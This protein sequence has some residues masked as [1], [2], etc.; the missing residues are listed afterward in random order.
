ML[1]KILFNYQHRPAISDS[2]FTG[3][4][5]K[6]KH[7]GYF[8]L[9]VKERSGR[10]IRGNDK[11]N[12]RNLSVFWDE[13][14]RRNTDKRE[15]EAPKK[16][17]KRKTESRLFPGVSDGSLVS[18]LSGRLNPAAS[19]LLLSSPLKLRNPFCTALAVKEMK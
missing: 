3:N 14:A 5:Q 12:N 9:D 8:Q 18:T 15:D 4:M 19:F 17:T 2:V 16:K 7:L 10:T 1:K 13:D 11:K 6:K